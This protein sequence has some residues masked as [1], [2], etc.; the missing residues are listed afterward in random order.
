MNARVSLIVPR[1]SALGERLAQSGAP[2]LQAILFFALGL[3]LITGFLGGSAAATAAGYG[4][5]RTGVALGALI[6]PLGIVIAG[7]GWRRRLVQVSV[8]E[9]GIVIH[10]R[11]GRIARSWGQIARV[12]ERT[13]EQKRIFGRELTEVFYFEDRKGHALVVDDRL[14]D[15][16]TIGRLA[17]KLAQEAMREG[18]EDAASS[19]RR[20]DFGALTLDDWGIHTDEAAFPWSSIAFVRWETVFLRAS[21]AIHLTSG[22]TP[23]T[24]ASDEIANEHVVLALLERRGKLASLAPLMNETAPVAA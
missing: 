10:D 14:P 5:L 21:L 13:V 12:F 19:G 20:L 2:S 15:H 7:R 23:I 24:I 16:V 18:Y 6:L 17:S 4:S 22:G 8:H 11:R 9:N 3:G 1:G